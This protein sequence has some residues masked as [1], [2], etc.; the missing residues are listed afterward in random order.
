MK[1]VILLAAVVA[2]MLA[3]CQSKANKAEMAQADSLAMEEMA[4]VTEATEVFEGTITSPNGP[5]VQYVLTLDMLADSNDTVYALD[6]TLLDPKNPGVTKTVG[7]KGKP[8]VIHKVVKDK[9]K[10]EVTKKAIKLNPNDGSAPMYFV[11]VNDTT[12]TLV[13]NEGL[14]ESVSEGTCNLIRVKQ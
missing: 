11:V 9:N 10:K 14:D 7:S 4:P 1:K 12:L 13:N 5:A 3:S 2:A 8:Q 6:M